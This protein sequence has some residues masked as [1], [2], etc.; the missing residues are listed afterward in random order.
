MKR[1]KFYFST[2]TTIPY[3]RILELNGYSVSD[4]DLVL[5]DTYFTVFIPYV[6]SIQ[7]VTL[8]TKFKDMDPDFQEYGGYSIVD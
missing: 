7:A 8:N 3:K 2:G 1:I 6:D 4:D 5:N